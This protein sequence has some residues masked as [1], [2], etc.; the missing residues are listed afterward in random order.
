M[1]NPILPLKGGAIQPGDFRSSVEL[2]P[3]FF[4]SVSLHV[5]KHRRDFSSEKARSECSL[6]TA[7]LILAF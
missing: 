3:A 6:P 7:L 5:A 2:C 4:T 1:L